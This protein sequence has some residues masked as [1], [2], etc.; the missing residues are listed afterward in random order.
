MEKKY[1]FHHFGIIVK[2]PRAGER[3]S[4][5]FKMYTSGGLDSDF[6][7][8]YHRFE[9]GCPLHPLIQTLPHIAFKVPDLLEAIKGRR[10]LMEP[11]EPFKGFKV[12]IIEVSGAPVEFLET[13]L[14][15]EE[16]WNDKSHED[17]V[18]YPKDR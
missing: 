2:E 5:P 4:E 13:S 14:S 1:E 12:A 11:Y 18:I 7:I 10:V 8:Q 16:I 3:Y 17:S 6:R 15:E 9:E